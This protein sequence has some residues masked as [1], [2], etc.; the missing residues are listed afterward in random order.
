MASD[1][2]G[3]PGGGSGG[4]GG[5]GPGSRPRDSGE[6]EHSVTLRSVVDQLRLL[7][8]AG[9]HLDLD[10]ILLRTTDVNRPGL[11]LTGYLEHFAPDRFQIIG[12]I[13]TAYLSGLDPLI[14]A[15]RLDEYFARGFPALVVARGL[16]VM[17]DMVA[18][19]DR[20]D[21][22]V[23][24]TELDTSKFASRLTWLLMHALA[25]RV[26]LDAGLVDV[27]GEGVLLLGDA[28]LG[29]SE[30]V[31]E[32]VR[33]GHR[34]ISAGRVQVRRI[35]D[36]HLRGRAPVDV[37][38]VIDIPGVGTVDVEELFG[39]GSIRIDVRVTVAVVM[40]SRDLDK[41]YERVGIV[42]LVEEVFGVPLSRVVIP[43]QPGRNL[44]VI[45][46]AVALTHRQ[47]TLGY[48]AANELSGP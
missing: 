6:S 13:E 24:G 41:E 9:G 33:R 23:F 22:P 25:P 15:A 26:E 44:A 40:E 18:A 10:E 1:S 19:A 38:H 2:S 34:L 35:T 45:V 39:I 27:H 7:Q 8:V 3:T 37:G 20:Y 17:P 4:D 47:R 43:V 21:V 31:L 5:H 42:E 29:R 48:V 28:S 46:E 16:H 11:E 14:R 32:L 30:T 36:N 12:W